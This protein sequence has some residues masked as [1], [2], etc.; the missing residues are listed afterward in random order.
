MVGLIFKILLGFA[1]LVGGTLVG[2]NAAGVAK[3]GTIALRVPDV[4]PCRRAVAE[5]RPEYVHVRWVWHAKAYGWG[6][7]YELEDGT[8]HTIAPMPR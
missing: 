8:T 4:E 3:P 6:C 2:L 1:L 7:F 5:L